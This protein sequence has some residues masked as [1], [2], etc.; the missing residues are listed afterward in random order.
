MHT[1]AYRPIGIIRSPYKSPKGTPIQPTGAANQKGKVILDSV[2]AGALDDLD[3]FSHLYLIYHFHLAKKYT[4]KITPFLDS[5]SR[6]LFS[7]RAP[8]R[9]NAIGLS[10]V[11]LDRIEETTLH[12]IDID[13]VDGTPLL[14]IKPYV[15][16]F[17]QR[18]KVKIGWMTGK[19]AEVND[20]SDDGRFVE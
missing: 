18:G 15:P 5:Q 9:P 2:Y 14:D 3:G 19:S 8:A 12:V 20:L 16:A 7:T 13:V 1:I 17:D 11:R 4:N 6:G 10:V